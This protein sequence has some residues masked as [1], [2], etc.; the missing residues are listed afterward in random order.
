MIHFS[1]IITSLNGEKALP[2]CLDA[3]FATKWESFDVIVV[4]N[5]STDRTSE[6]VRSRPDIKLIRSSKNLGFAGGNNLGLKEARGD[7]VILLN[8]DTEVYPDWLA[9]LNKAANEHPEAGILGC[10]LLYPG[11]EVIQHAGGRLEPNGLSKHIGYLEEDR[12][13]YDEITTCDY[14][15]GAAMAISRKT[16]DK[17]GPLD[18]GFF[19][20]YF[21]EID[22]CVQARKAGLEVLYVPAARVIHHESR[23]TERYSPGFLY[24]YHKNRLRFLFKNKTPCQ[25]LGALKYEFLWLIRNKPKDT[26]FPLLKSWLYII[27][28]I[29]FLM[30]KKSAGRP[31]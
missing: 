12:G 6:L 3:L 18:K 1:V 10:K 8:D 28:R 14:V 4:D 31:S 22:Y 24:K 7:W 26:Y 11:G 16:I 2:P 23:T 17:I 5:G 25:L 30:V 15:T 13:Q 27:P 21:E 20:I 29:P 19:P 9:A